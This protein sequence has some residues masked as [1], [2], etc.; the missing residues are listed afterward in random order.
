MTLEVVN[1]I[2]NIGENEYI[3]AEFIFD[4]KNETIWITQKKL[5]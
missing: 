4:D 2:W 3:F 5:V 1:R